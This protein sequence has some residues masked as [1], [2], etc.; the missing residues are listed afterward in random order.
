MRVIDA[1]SEILKRE[2][3]EYLPCFP[4][5]PVIESAAGAGI[6]AHCL[7]TGTRWRRYC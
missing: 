3:V 1:I 4:T 2:G 7:P 5:T 6:R